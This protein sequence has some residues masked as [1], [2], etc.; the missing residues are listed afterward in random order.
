MTRVEVAV[1]SER[2]QGLR[3]SDNCFCKGWEKKKLVFNEYL[4]PGPFRGED[5]IKILT[6]TGSE[7]A[8]EIRPALE[9]DVTW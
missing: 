8:E 1:L 4:E 7:S 9:K 5:T 2:D 3:Y 6:P